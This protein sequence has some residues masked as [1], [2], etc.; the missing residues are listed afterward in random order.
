MRHSEEIV[1]QFTH[2][3]AQFAQSSAARNEEILERILRMARPAALDDALDVACGPGVL[4]CA[5][6]QR[7]RQATGIDLTPAMLEQAASTAS[8]QGV[9][10]V[11]W[12][13]GDVTALPWNEGTF[14]IVTCRFAFH[15]FQDPLVV[16]REMRRVCRPGGRIVV[17]D[18]APAAAKA[19][20]FNAMERLRDPSHT[21]ALPAEEL[22][23]LFLEG[24][25]PEPQVEQM[26]LRLDLDDLLMR[27]YP[28]E[29]DEAR[30]R[31]MLEAA[32]AEDALDVKPRREQGRIALSFPIAILAAEVPHGG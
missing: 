32:L 11:S 14:S 2:Q 17:A 10:N 30:I 8:Q 21:R 28:R 18:S 6:A 27:S 23:E 20:A 13:L 1:D 31:A 25:L 3:A 19:D 29:G 12:K 7:A 24:G 16:L 22:R 26:R 15:H 4:V 5:L 9:G